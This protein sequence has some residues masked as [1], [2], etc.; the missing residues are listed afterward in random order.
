MPI[1]I[2]N[3]KTIMENI[4]AT[5]MIYGQ[6]GAGKTTLAAGFPRP[7]FLCAEDGLMSIAGMDVDYIKVVTPEDIEEAYQYLVSPKASK[8]YDTVIV[9]TLTDLQ[10]NVYMPAILGAN[11]RKFPEIR[12]WGQLLELMRRFT[13]Q[14]RDL[15]D[16]YD[17]IVFICQEQEYTDE[18]DNTFIRPMLTGKFATE[19]PAYV[20]IVMRL[21]VET[22]PRKVGVEPE[23]TRVAIF[24]PSRDFVAKDRSNTMPVA[25]R[26]PV[27]SKVLAKLRGGTKKKK[28]KKTVK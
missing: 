17:N 2:R 21:V 5:L 8:K 11:N 20:D 23:R 15:K 26:E 16:K 19:A 6:S 14:M 22:G 7:I 27:A 25:M 4:H 13:R 28:S 10:N 24:Q 1:E 18:N 3:T 9:D 12:D